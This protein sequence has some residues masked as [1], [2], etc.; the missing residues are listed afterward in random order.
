MFLKF[1]AHL[2]WRC[3]RFG[4]PETL[5]CQGSSYQDNENDKELVYRGSLTSKI[6]KLKFFSLMTTVGSLAAQPFLYMRMLDED[7][8]IPI[9]SFIVI[10]IFVMANPL[11]IY[12][13]TKRYVLDLYFYPKE[14]KYVVEVFN[15]FFQKRKIEFSPNDVTVPKKITAF[16]TLFVKNNPMLFDFSFTNNSK[17]Y[18]IIIGYKTFEDFEVEPLETNAVNRL[19]SPVNRSQRVI[20]NKSKKEQ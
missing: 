12:L 5:I 4:T 1:R 9:L 8:A 19:P 13:L 14:R 10:N 3:K 11:F 18:F 6:R 17:H 16:T 2:K 7:N 20:E 15:F